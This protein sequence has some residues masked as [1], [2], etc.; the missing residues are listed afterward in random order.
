MN[1]EWSN[2][3]WLTRFGGYVPLVQDVFES[4]ITSLR[5]HS[6]C[7]F[8]T[9][10]LLA[11]SPFE[12]FDDLNIVTA[13]AGTTSGSATA[14]PLNKKRAMMLSFMLRFASKIWISFW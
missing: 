14:R 2:H 5:W 8:P 7:R 6:V 13:S 3:N 4:E 12:T 10:L 11:I 1:N 9:A